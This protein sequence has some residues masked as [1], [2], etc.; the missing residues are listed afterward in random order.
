[1]GKVFLVKDDL[2]NIH[3]LTIYSTMRFFGRKFRKEE[4]EIREDWG[5]SNGTR[6][7]DEIVSILCASFLFARLRR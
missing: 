7:A 3:G 2:G 5:S 1:M 4:L 6:V